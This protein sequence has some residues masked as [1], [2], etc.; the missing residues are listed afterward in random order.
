MS[1]EPKIIIEEDVQEHVLVGQSIRVKDYRLALLLCYG[2][3]ILLSIL[4]GFRN[5]GFL[6]ALFALGLFLPLGRSVYEAVVD[7]RYF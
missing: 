7:F 4:I 2:L 3:P 5:G 6:F 1:S